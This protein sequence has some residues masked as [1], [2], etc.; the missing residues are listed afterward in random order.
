MKQPLTATA[1]TAICVLVLFL[2]SCTVSGQLAL[3]GDASAQTGLDVQLS[4]EFA[5][6]L[7]DLSGVLGMVDEPISP[8]DLQALAA[9]FDA[10][11]GVRLV[12]GEIPD[13]SRLNVRLDIED[14]ERAFT[15]GPTRIEGLVRLEDEG[16]DRIMTVTLSRE[17]IMEL[18]SVTPVS[19]QS[20]IEFLLPPEGMGVDEYVD[21]L[22]WAMEEYETDTPIETI[23]RDARLTVRVTAP[24]EIASVSGGVLVDGPDGQAADF[25][26]RVVTLLTTDQPTS[27]SVRYRR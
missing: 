11:P 7:L 1:V 3:R 20:S 6:Y 8:F 16:G 2:A 14:M 9:A 15:E 26:E 21:Y 27:W 22:A 4:D 5:S 18:T 23:I 19:E 25:S 17:R 12:A 10:E 24:G 13:P